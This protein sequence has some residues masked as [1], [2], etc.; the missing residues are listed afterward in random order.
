MRSWKSMLAAA[1]VSCLPVLWTGCES[2][3]Q[4]EPASFTTTET[5]YEKP[6]HFESAINSAYSRL[7]AQAGIANTAYR[8]ITELRFDC[9]ITDPQRLS[10]SPS[11]KPI[12]EWYAAPSNAYFADQWSRAYHTIAQTNTILSRVDG[13]TFEDQTQKDQIIGQAKFIRALSYWYL[14]QFYGAVPLVLAEVKSP[15]EAMPSGRAPVEEVY[16]QIVADLQDAVAKLPVSWPQPG[17]ATKGAAEFL[18]GRTYLLTQDYEKAAA[19]LGIVVGT[20][21]VSPY[22]Y[23]L[24]DN[25]RDVFDPGNVNNAESIFELQFGAGVAGQ[26]DMGLVGDLLPYNSRGQIVPASVGVSGDMLASMQLVDRYE[27]G[28]ARKE[29][30]ILWW[31]DPAVDSAKAVLKKFVWPEYVNAQGQQAGNVILFRFAD[32]LLSLAEAEWRLGNG[33]KAIEYV[34]RV[35]RRAGLAPIDL[36]H[37]AANPLLA[38]TYLETDPVGRAIFNERTVELA[39]EGHRMLDLVRFG[40]AYEVM[41]AWAKETWAKNPELKGFFLI[42]PTEILLPIPSQEIA[43]TNGALEQNPGW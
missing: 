4:P 29:A 33:P 31:T 39:G 43:A 30:S 19:A 24:L 11:G 1:G 16:A 12:A 28:D 8:T 34:D 35:R 25:Y 23:R 18:L 36:A 15:E 6:E 13:V 40:V 27:P 21:D 37:V 42:E 9:C 38:G 17:R 3:L 32:A 5:Y 7:R 20:G 2:F 41:Q 10:T 14:V 22:G 26:P